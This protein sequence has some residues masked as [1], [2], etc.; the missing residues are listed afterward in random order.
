MKFK[1]ALIF[2]HACSSLSCQIKDS[3]YLEKIAI[4]RN[5]L[6][7]K[8][9]QQKIPGL[10]ITV[11]RNDTTLWSEGM[12]YADLSLGVKVKPEST[13]FRIA[14]ISK[15]L[16]ATGLAKIYES[17]LIDLETSIYQYIPEFPKKRYDIK[18]SHLANHSSGIRHYKTGEFRNK[19]HY[20]IEDGIKLFS[21]DSLLFRPGSRFYYSSYGWNLLSYIIQERSGLAFENFMHDSIFCPL[22]MHSTIP[23]EGMWQSRTVSK[24]YAKKANQ[25]VSEAQEVSNYHKLGSGGFLSTT[26]DLAKLANSYLYFNLI[27]KTTV[28]TFTMP[29]KVGGNTVSYGLGW[30]LMLDRG[31]VAGFYHNGKGV[32]AYGF[33]MIYMES[34]VT[35]SVLCNLGEADFE[36]EI[37]KI[38][39]LFSAN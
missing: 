22:E 24:F 31:K 32:G 33:I 16:T 28:R 6:E 7:K 23:D 35:V 25:E 10:S 14:S 9:V 12:G 27:S 18:V 26:H 13:L 5:L 1:A 30:N 19:S 17:G 21:K 39:K 15:C 37:F 4:S 36:N 34:R 20:S 2:L 3:S 8:I 29:Q 38:G 11:T